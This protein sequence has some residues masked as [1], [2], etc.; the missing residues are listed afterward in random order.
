MTVRHSSRRP[1]VYLVLGWLDMNKGANYRALIG[2][3]ALLVFIGFEGKP[4]PNLRHTQK[5]RLVDGVTDLL[6]DLDQ[7]GSILAI[8]V[9]LRHHSAPV[10]ARNTLAV[11]IAL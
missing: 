10:K 9:A 8:L 4:L 1:Q 3:A 2:W 6:R 5:H 7:L 11:L